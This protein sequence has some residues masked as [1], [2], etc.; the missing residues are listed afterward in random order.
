MKK[1]AN[2]TT[3]TAED[4]ATIVRMIAG[5]SSYHKIALAIGKGLRGQDINNRWHR[6][7]KESS[8]IIKP[9]VKTG[10]HSSITWTAEDDARMI[11]GCSSYPEIALAMGKGKGCRGQ[12]INNRWYRE[13]KESSTIIKPPVKTGPHSSWT[14]EDDAIIVRMIMHG[15]SYPEIALAM[16]IGLKVQVIS[17]R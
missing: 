12:D 4:D 15:S 10:P 7:L 2:H 13:L 3:W 11:L 16:G 5:G 9:P 14:A 17:N 6:E 8:A 1:E